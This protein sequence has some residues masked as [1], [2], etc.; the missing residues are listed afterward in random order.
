MT[1]AYV[2]RLFIFVN[3]VKKELRAFN[4]AKLAKTC[5]IRENVETRKLIPLRYLK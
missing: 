5:E 3:A 2:W 4:F 1:L